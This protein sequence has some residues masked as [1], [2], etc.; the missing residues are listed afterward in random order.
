MFKGIKRNA[1][2]MIQGRGGELLMKT[3]Q[4]LPLLKWAAT[5]SL[6]TTGLSFSQALTDHTEEEL[7]PQLPGSSPVSAALDSSAPEPSLR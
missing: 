1:S 6:F 4:M 5:L 7:H 2:T 3:A